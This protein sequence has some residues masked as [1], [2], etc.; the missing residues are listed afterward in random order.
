MIFKQK[1]KVNFIIQNFYL[2]QSKFC[3][4]HHFQIYL[5]NFSKRIMFST[6][7]EK[8]AKYNFWNNKK[9][10]TGFFRKDYVNN[11]LSYLNNKLVKVILGQRRVGKSY[12]MRMIMSQLI[13]KLNVPSKNILYINMDIHDF[14]FIT[15]YKILSNVVDEYKRKLKP[16][17]KI[18]IFIDEIQE[19]ENWEKLINSFTQ[20]FLEEYEIFITGSNANLLSSELSTYLS[21]RYVP[22][23][24]FP[25]SYKEFLSYFNLN[26]S[27]E[28][29]LKYL[30]TGGMPEIYN[31][32][33]E[34]V[35][36]NYIFSLKDSILLRDVIKRFKIRDIG[37][38][39]KLI[40]FIIDNIGNLFSINSIVKTLKNQGF[41]SNA[42]TLTNYIEALKKSYFIHEV[43]RF[44][45]KGKK[46]LS[47]ERKFYINDT[48]FKYF[49]SST[50]DFGIG[51]YLEN[52]VFIELK[53]RGY[54]VYV[55]KIR[56]MEVDFIAE[57]NK[58]KVYIQV[59]Y[60]LNNR[61]VID[62]E[63]NNLLLIKDHF[64]KYVL[65]LDDL[66]LGNINGVKHL[67]IND[68]CYK[69]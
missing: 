34:E 58:E 36:Q 55:G 35:K 43:V 30:K 24:I 62:R 52:I 54:N 9:I 38:M 57:K 50:F 26:N 47:G 41:K 18:Y 6:M 29:F 5:K 28:N 27:K 2:F 63:F 16:E 46:I 14:D 25:F 10:N 32:T 23:L 39:E 48:S 17:G 44:D 3:I 1:C 42:E 13:E 31:L 4:N 67:K 60:L 20:D 65:S 37:L 40:D 59:A 11:I 64:P 45:I 33:S 22:F 8:I 53:R 61:D 66:E 19:I 69:F 15:N 21:G 51:K 49:L 68:F 56:D 12:I 7:I